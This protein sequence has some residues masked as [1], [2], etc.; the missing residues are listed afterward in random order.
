M[1][2]CPGLTAAC[3]PRFPP[4][5]AGLRPA[6]SCAQGP[7]AEGPAVAAWGWG[8]DAT[9]P[10][11]NPRPYLAEEPAPLRDEN[12]S[13][14]VTSPDNTR[15][16]SWGREVRPG[17]LGCAALTCRR[18]GRVHLWARHSGLILLK[19][20]AVCISRPCASGQWMLTS[21]TLGAAS[22]L[23]QLVLQCERRGAGQRPAPGGRGAGRWW[24]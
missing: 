13:A 14:Q 21:A 20:S 1:R 11:G 2:S 8:E 19:P 12:T 10:S 18:P 6:A 17:T 15:P 24:R 7:P 23:R 4:A 3:P 5:T 9:C 22:A 16:W